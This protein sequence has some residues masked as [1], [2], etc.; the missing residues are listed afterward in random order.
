MAQETAWGGTRQE[1]KIAYVFK[2]SE[3]QDP[4]KW[5]WRRAQRF[6]RILAI[7]GPVPDWLGAEVQAYWKVKEEADAHQQVGTA[8]AKAAMVDVD[9]PPT[10]DVPS[11]APQPQ[12]Q[13]V[14]PPNPAKK[15][16]E[17]PSQPSEP[18]WPH[19]EAAM[20]DTRKRPR[21]PLYEEALWDALF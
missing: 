5:R 4:S 18:S 15:A 21:S 10:G 8:R 19:A 6:G 16:T 7:G 9:A 2:Q 13:A 14:Q 17:T 3:V 1:S 11:H 12:P 20:E